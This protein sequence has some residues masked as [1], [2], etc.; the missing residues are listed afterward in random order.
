MNIP[1]ISLFKS[2]FIRKIF[3]HLKNPEKN[4]KKSKKKIRKK[5][6]K[7]WKKILG[8]FEDLKSVHPIWEWKT[9]RLKSV[10]SSGV[11]YIGSEWCIGSVLI[12]C[13]S[14]ISS[15]YYLVDIG[16]GP[17]A[18]AIICQ[19]ILN[20]VDDVTADKG[21]CNVR[22]R[23]ADLAFPFDTWYLI[24]GLYWQIEWESMDER[25]RDSGVLLADE[26]CRNII[27]FQVTSSTCLFRCGQD[28]FPS[29]VFLFLGSAQL[30]YLANLLNRPKYASFFCN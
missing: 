19:R 13:S 28:H 7:I 6:R 5:I 25:L 12:K 14:T 24:V 2:F 3:V 9:P 11:W 1:S 29:F 10:K 15:N 8:I 16:S 20:S 23:R 22:K 27:S 4:P 17:S 18:L 26:S 21:Q 30:Y